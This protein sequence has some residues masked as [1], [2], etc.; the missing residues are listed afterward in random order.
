MREHHKAIDNR[1]LPNFVAE[2]HESRSAP[3]VRLALELLIL[4]PTRTIEVLQARWCEIDWS[5]NC[6]TIPA[7]RTK[8]SRPHAVPLSPATVE[9]LTEAQRTVADTKLV[10]EGRSTAKPLSQDALRI[11]MRRT[12]GSETPHAFRS[13]F[14]DWSAERTN[15]PREVCGAALAHVN[16]NKTEAAYFRTTVF[17]KR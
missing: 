7:E 9:V 3:T 6:G 5:E 1:E 2:L 12:G 16:P 17:D 14:R 4:T 13:T 15:F 10:F 11:A 8:S